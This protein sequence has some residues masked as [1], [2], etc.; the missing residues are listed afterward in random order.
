MLINVLECL[1]NIG[2]II[3]YLLRRMS[4]IFTNMNYTI[5]HFPESRRFTTNIDGNTA[6]ITYNRIDDKMELTHTIVPEAI[7]GRGV[8]AALVKEVLRYARE[9]HLYIIPV[10]S[11]TVT[12][13]QRHP[14]DSDLLWSR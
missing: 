3:D 6:Y 7:A 1:I 4:E 9:N 2:R 10:C 13:F 12:Y 8:A 11:Y 5:T 14:E